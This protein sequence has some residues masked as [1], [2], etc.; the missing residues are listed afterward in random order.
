MPCAFI[1]AHAP[2]FQ[3]GRCSRPLFVPLMHLPQS[4]CI[5]FF[6]STHLHA[7]VLLSCFKDAKV[8]IIKHETQKLEMHIL[9]LH[10]FNDLL[11]TN[12]AKLYRVIVSLG[13]KDFQQ[14]TTIYATMAV[15]FYRHTP[16]SLKHYVSSQKF[17]K[18]FVPGFHAQLDMML[19][20]FLDTELSE[21][22]FGR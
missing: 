9:I 22:D 12:T 8:P 10:K 18:V 11:I 2:S 4:F 6:S 5:S 20:I 1:S 7:I 15:K 17:L 14:K 16:Q 13:T 3:D 21:S 19:R